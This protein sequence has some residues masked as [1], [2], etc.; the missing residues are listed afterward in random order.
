MTSNEVKIWIIGSV[1][2]FLIVVVVAGAIVTNNQIE[3]QTKL[4]VTEVV[5]DAK[6]ER[7]KERWGSLPFFRKDR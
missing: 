3:N 2:V 6:V 1:T 7:T 4:K 5:E